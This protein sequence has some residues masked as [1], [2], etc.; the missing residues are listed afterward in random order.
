MSFWAYLKTC[1][2]RIQRKRK[3]LRQVFTEIL[4]YKLFTGL[5]FYESSSL[6]PLLK[7]GTGSFSILQNSQCTIEV[8]YLVL[9][10]DREC[11]I[12]F[13]KQ[14]CGVA[15]K[16]PRT[17][18][19]SEVPELYSCFLQIWVEPLQC[20]PQLMAKKPRLKLAVK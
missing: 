3:L 1:R 18:S 5:F 8:T 19:A 9:N 20:T 16:L 4:I 14:N 17:P 7:T 13:M 6:V 10:T 12:D 2:A 15:T 11:R